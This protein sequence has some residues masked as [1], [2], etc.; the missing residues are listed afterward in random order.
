MAMKTPRDLFV[1]ELSDTYNAEKQILEMLPTLASESTDKELTAAFK[2][3]EKET[4]QQ[5]KNLDEAFKLLGEKPEDMVCYGAEGLRKEHDSFLEEKPTPE[6][7]TLFVA[8]AAAKTE[9]YEI[10]SYTGLIDMARLMGEKEITGL[11]QE[12]LKQE[13]EMAKK[14]E[15]FE[16]KLG[17]EIVPQMMA[18]MQESSSQQAK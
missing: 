1:H 13:K 15:Q 8:G 10:E 14:A 12:N 7:L 17:K 16:K 5:I 3:H 18:E 6:I 9:H 2:E 11:L 4:R